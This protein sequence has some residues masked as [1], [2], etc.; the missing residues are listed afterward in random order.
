MKKL[1]FLILSLV[2]MAACNA[3]VLDSIPQSNS[4]AY[5]I[6]QHSFA[7]ALHV[8]NTIKPT[9]KSFIVPATL[10]A[11]GFVSLENKNLKDLNINTKVE[12][13]EHHSAPITKLDNYLQYAPAIAVYG[14][15]AL[16]IKGKNN[17]RDRT[18]IYGLSTVISSAIVIPLKNITKVQRPDGSGFNSFP[19]GHTTTAFAAAE[20]MRQEYKDVSPWYGITGYAAATATAVLR[21]YN[22]K[23]WVSDVVAGAGFGILSTKL[24]YW[25]YPSIKRNFFKDK[26]MNTMVMPF[27]QNGGGG[28]AMIYNFH[29]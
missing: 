14:L 29:H 22:N 27:Y 15:N 3:Q 12:I 13:K 21:L 23:H 11:Y 6:S 20:F 4:N 1:S 7:S 26:P 19:S 10:I 16:G 18:I 25:I 24:A 2:A 17:F 28:L 8:P 5:N 9:I